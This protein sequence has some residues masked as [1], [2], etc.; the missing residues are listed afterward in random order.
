AYPARRMSQTSLPWWAG[1][2]DR[3]GTMTSTAALTPGKKETSVRA[4]MVSEFGGPEQL[5]MGRVA[6]PV[7][8]PGQVRVAV[9][10]AGVNPV[11]AGTASLVLARLGLP[12][13]SRLLVLG[14]SG[15]VGLFVLQLAAAAGITTIG[16]GREA[17]HAQMRG[18][19]AAA[20][21]DYT[22]EDVAAR[23]RVLADG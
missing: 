5:R 14:G 10:A 2:T 16:T 12:P 22:R 13:G 15:G 3:P 6:D 23:A 11:A 20:C 19:G 8:G 7:A 17:M 21:I 1:P 18:L 4:V 9:R